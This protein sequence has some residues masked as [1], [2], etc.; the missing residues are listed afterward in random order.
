VQQWDEYGTYNKKKK[1]IKKKKNQKISFSALRRISC[2]S[3]S[4]LSLHVL[5]PQAS[6]IEMGLNRRWNRW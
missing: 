3:T 5:L 4:S 2:P 6:V 1:M